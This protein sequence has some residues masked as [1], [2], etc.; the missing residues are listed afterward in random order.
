MSPNKGESNSDFLNR[1]IE[2]LGEHFDTVQI[3]AQIDTPESTI[4]FC[5]GTGNIFARVKQ[6][7]MFV[8]RFNDLQFVVDFKEEDEEDDE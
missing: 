7:E 3:F 4:P 2:A 6:A 8:D 5:A 1:I